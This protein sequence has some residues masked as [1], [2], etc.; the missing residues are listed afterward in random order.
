MKILLPLLQ[1]A[2]ST[3]SLLDSIKHGSTIHALITR[4]FVMRIKKIKTCFFHLI[5]VEL[6]AQ[7]Q[8]RNDPREDNKQQ[9]KRH[10]GT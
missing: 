1:F 4:F 5:D 9:Q 2:V 8:N 6:K 10:T 3:T 7:Q